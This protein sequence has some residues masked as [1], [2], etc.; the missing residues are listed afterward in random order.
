MSKKKHIELLARGVFVDRGRVL[1]C[2]T[3]GASNT[4]LPGGHVEFG[5]SARTALCREIKEELGRKAVAGRFLGVVE[6]S[7]MQKGK[8]HCEVNFVFEMD[9]KGL[10][11]ERIP[12]SEEDY[13]EFLWVPLKRLRAS[14][15]Q[16]SALCGVLGKWLKHRGL[17]EYWASVP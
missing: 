8:R 17:D 16:P 14:N 1:L 7:F 5:E 11:S 10:R 13:I 12:L 6:N 2:H 9:V 3:K 15:L 4:Y